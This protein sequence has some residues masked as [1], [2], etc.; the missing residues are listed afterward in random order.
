MVNGMNRA[1]RRDYAVYLKGKG[2]LFDA[3]EEID[4]TFA[5]QRKNWLI[6][7]Q[8]LFEM[9]HVYLTREAWE[10]FSLSEWLEV[11]EA[12][13]EALRSDESGSW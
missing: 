5:L 3:M 8:D 6:R 2:Y 11:E 13:I 9:N 1:E 10:M 4:V 12:A 7:S